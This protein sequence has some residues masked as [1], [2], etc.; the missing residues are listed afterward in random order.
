M[1]LEFGNLK[2]SRLSQLRMEYG[3]WRTEVLDHRTKEVT[4]E[5][6]GASLPQARD[7]CLKLAPLQSKV[8]LEGSK[9]VNFVSMRPPE[10]RVLH[11]CS[12]YM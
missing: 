11:V 1:K 6:H 2:N 7:C 10:V 5:G 12:I 9:V 8:A 4:F 3:A